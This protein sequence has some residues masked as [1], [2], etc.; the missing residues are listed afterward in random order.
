MSQPVTQLTPVLWVAQS[1]LFHTNSSIFISEGRACLVDPGIYPDEI[2]GIA[3][4]LVEQGA[5]AD[6]IVLTHIHWDHILGS[7]RF[8]GAKVIAHAA[9]P[10]LAEQYGS[11]ILGDIASWEEKYDI[12]RDQPFTIPRPDE[13]FAEATALNAGSLTLELAHSTRAASPSNWRTAPATR[14]TR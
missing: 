11:Y 14:P 13:T 3:A 6:A 9:F 7:E 8:P 2:E 12:E 5:V 10:G 1:R 4:F